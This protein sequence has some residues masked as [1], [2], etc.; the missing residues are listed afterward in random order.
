MTIITIIT[1]PNPPHHTNN[2]FTIQL[3]PD[4]TTSIQQF[5]LL[6]STLVFFFVCII[7]PTPARGG[8]TRERCGGEWV[9]TWAS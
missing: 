5:H 7:Y 8:E 6:P 2:V 1:D 4:P 3:L 9:E